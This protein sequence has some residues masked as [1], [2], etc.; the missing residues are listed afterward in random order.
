M[1]DDT[2]ATQTYIDSI[3]L[4]SAFLLGFFIQGALIEPLGRK[5]I[6]LYSSIICALCA[7]LL[8]FVNNSL[9]IMILFCLM[10]LIPGLLISVMCGAIVDLVPTYFR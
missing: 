5:N 3:I 6:L 7:F 4:G 8:N 9:A 1:C 10:I 2:I